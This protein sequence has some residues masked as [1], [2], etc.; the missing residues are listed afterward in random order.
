MLFGDL[1]AL[2]VFGVEGIADLPLLILLRKSLKDLLVDRAL[3]EEARRLG[4]LLS[5]AGEHRH[6]RTLDGPGH[7]GGVGKDDVR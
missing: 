2:I 4:A 6:E 1:R 3:D 5:L 7:V